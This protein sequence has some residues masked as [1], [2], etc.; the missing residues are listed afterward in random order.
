MNRFNAVFG[1][2]IVARVFSQA[3]A[4]ETQ[5]AGLSSEVEGPRAKAQTHCS[6][7]QGSRPEPVR[8]NVGLRL[9][10]KLRFRAGEQALNIAA[11]A[12]DDHHGQ[13]CAGLDQN[14]RIRKK[15]E[16]RWRR[17]RSNH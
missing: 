5:F 15:P 3:F 12:Q 4:S 1:A 13:E 14:L 16:H 10:I 11:V 17:G 8:K 7:L 6:R 2:R 9:T